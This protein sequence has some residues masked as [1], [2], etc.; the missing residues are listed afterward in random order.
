[1]Q[2]INGNVKR[3]V[4]YTSHKHLQI[5]LQNVTFW[6]TISYS[7]INKFLQN[8]SVSQTTRCHVSQCI[9]F[10]VSTLSTGDRGVQRLRCCAT[11]HTVAGSI[12]ASVNGCFIDIKSFRSHCG[13]GVDSASNRIEYQEQ[14]LGVKAVGA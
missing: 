1:M 9:T 14:F 11:N 10:S 3:F 4:V 13:P 8:A 2:S 7:V 5:D 6:D 12:P